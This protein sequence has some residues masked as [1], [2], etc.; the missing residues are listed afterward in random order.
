MP[1]NALATTRAAA[2]QCGAGSQGNTMNRPH[3][4]GDFGKWIARC[5]M[6]V[7]LQAG[8]PAHAEGAA[9]KA[10]A[11]TDALIPLVVLDSEKPPAA[12]KVDDR[13]FPWNG[14]ALAS[15][16][17]R[18]L[19]AIM[20]DVPLTKANVKRALLLT[21]LG[22]LE[23]DAQGRPAA[24]GPGTQQAWCKD[25]VNLNASIDC[26]R[27]SDGDGKLDQHARGYLPR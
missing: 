21:Y 24:G 18:P 1:S 12:V 5:S 16:P 8:L 11:F 13:G 19:D 6:L 20:I 23:L 9:D 15:Q 17:A 3:G 7:L 26:F 14:V 2:A 25:S 10:D 22:K 27:D 4:T